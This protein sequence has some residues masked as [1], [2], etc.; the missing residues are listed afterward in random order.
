MP[1]GKLPKLKAERE[2][3][4][5]SS[6]GRSRRSS[7]DTSKLSRCVSIKRHNMHAAISTSNGVFDGWACRSA[8]SDASFPPLR[9]SNR[10]SQDAASNAAGLSG[11]GS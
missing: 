7:D 9:E 1:T 5:N 8:Q 3:T 2:R 6:K 10:S 4:R 11:W